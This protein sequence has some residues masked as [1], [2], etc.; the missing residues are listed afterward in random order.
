MKSSTIMPLSLKPKGLILLL[1]ILS[2]QAAGQVRI[3][4]PYS[5]YGL[6]NI[7]DKGMEPRTMGMGGIHYGLQKNDLVNPANPASYMAFDS[8]TFI[9][10]AGIFGIFTNL[11]TADLTQGGS[12]ISLSHLTFG[13]PVTK[14]WR[15][16]F[17][18]LPFSYVGYDVYIDEPV[19]QV[20][21]TR[22]VF[23]GSGGLNQLY[24][25]SGF[26]IGK[27]FSAGFNIKYLFGTIS[28]RQGVSF[29][30]SV[31]LKNVVTEASFTPSDIFGEIGAQYRTQL[32][33]D[34]F[35][36]AGAFIGPGTEISTKRR[37]LSTT[38]YGNF[39]SV[40][41]TRDTI[42]YIPREKGTFTLPFRTGMGVTVGHANQ[43]L[44]GADF[45]W[46]NWENFEYYGNSDS[47]ANSWR[48]NAGAEYTPDSRSVSDYWERMTY[49]MGFQY[50]K[51]QLILKDK[52]LDEFGISFG[53]SLPIRNSRSTLNTA[54]EFGKF[55]TTADKLV[56][57]NFIR[58]TV[59]VNVSENW[60]IRYK[61]R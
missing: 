15:T 53:F 61:Y 14:W 36:V 9:F 57:E 3:N 24:W 18:I 5:R 2:L 38:Y 13:F 34:L 45:S 6:G 27:K 40:L 30:D 25:G 48:I 1:S 42:E 16:S 10:D 33:K 50:G 46:Q 54:I 12:Y 39:N 58:F 29:P 41:Y 23:Q 43:W 20:G 28:R 22:F 8:L 37:R 26:R 51:S 32:P 52:H 7:V 56:Q 47:L 17:G 4:S 35:L 49:R 19:E 44:A 55:G 21:N 60:F 11:K 59:G 31:E